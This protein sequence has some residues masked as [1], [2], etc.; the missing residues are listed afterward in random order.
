MYAYICLRTLQ[1]TSVHCQWDGPSLQ[2]STPEP[3]DFVVGPILPFE[4]LLLPNVGTAHL[5]E[6]CGVALD[7]QK[8]A[9]ACVMSGEGKRDISV[10]Q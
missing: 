1:E 7:L 3:L 2:T 9:F 5:F 10:L 4:L 6:R 8:Q